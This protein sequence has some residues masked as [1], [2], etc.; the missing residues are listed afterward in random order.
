MV[1]AQDTDHDTDS[2]NGYHEVFQLNSSNGRP[3]YA[4][5][6][7]EAPHETTKFQVDCGATVSV[8]PKRLIKNTSK[9]MQT[10][11][12]RLRVYNGNT[13]VCW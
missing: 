6:K 13:V 3:L 11:G 1:T 9:S 12:T 5:M 2:N 10:T 8:I 4:A 7:I